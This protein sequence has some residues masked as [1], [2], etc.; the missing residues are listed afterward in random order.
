MP[1]HNR[2]CA[3]S[4]PVIVAGADRERLRPPIKHPAHMLGLPLIRIADPESFPNRVSDA[5]TTFNVRADAGPR[6]GHG[7]PEQQRDAHVLAAFMAAF[8]AAF[9]AILSSYFLFRNND[10]C[11]E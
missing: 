2:K 6:P 8:M 3:R 1:E 9:W 7:T 10:R 4:P 11:A 5:L